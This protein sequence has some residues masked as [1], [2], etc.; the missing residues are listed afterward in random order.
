[1]ASDAWNELISYASFPKHKNP[2][3][4]D[5]SKAR[6][7]ES[8]TARKKKKVSSVWIT[9]DYSGSVPVHGIY[10]HFLPHYKLIDSLP[11]HLFSVL[12]KKRKGN[13]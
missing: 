10:I 2:L 5:N 13:I 9:W 3:R 7:A 8:R 4:L 1:M 6:L 11:V 12:K